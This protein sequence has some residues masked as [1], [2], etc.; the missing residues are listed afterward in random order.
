MRRPR[1]FVALAG[2]ATLTAATVGLQAQAPPETQKQTID[3]VVAL[4]EQ[5]HMSRPEINDDV[6]KRA[7]VNFI[8]SLDPL[9][10]NFLKADVDGFLAESP[11]LDDQIRKGDISWA[12]RVFQ[13]FLKRSDERLET[14]KAIFEQ[15]PDF[16]QDETI[17]DDP[18]LI[19]FPKTAEEA[20][21]RL[22]K[23]IKLDLLQLKVSKVDEADALK[24]L[25]LR[26]FEPN[27]YYKLF[28]N[29]DL[30][31]RYLTA[32][33]TAV[34]PHSAYWQATTLEDMLGTTLHL[35][36][37]GIGAS[38]QSEDGF[39]VVKEVVPGGAA[40]KDGRLQPEDKILGIEGDNGQKEEF[41]GKKLSDVVRKIR[42][43]AGT[44][45]RLM[46]Q[47]AE[48][49]EIKV[50]ELTRQK[51]ELVEQKA[52][53][54]VL[55]AKGPD[56]KAYKVGVINLP[57]FY[58]DGVALRNNAPD[59]VSAT[60]D[61]KRLL[62]GFKGQGVN[63]VVVDL[64]GNGGGLLKEAVML[65]GLFIDEGPVVQIKES[66][67]V[68]HHDDD[69]KGTA[70]DGPMVVLIDHFSA[71]ASEIF[72]GVI[73]D[74][75][76]GL[77]IGDSSTYG[78]GTVQSIIRLN[79]ILPRLFTRNSPD[80]GA[81][82]LTIQQ[83]YRANGESTQI[84]GVRPDIHIPSPTDYLDIGEGKSETAVKYDKVAPLA[85]DDYRRVPADLVTKIKARSEER[86]QANAKF[87]DQAKAIERL[88]ARK[89]KHEITLNEEKF[90]VE[91]AALED[92]KDD[93]KPKEKKKHSERPAWESNFYND[94]ILA[95]L[96]DYLSLG[97]D[98]LTAGPARDVDPS[99]LPLRP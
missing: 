91:T 71:S 6:A 63:A 96:G 72:A 37:E 38:L 2:I 4:L 97:G 32:L 34:D 92:D 78:K 67:G 95:I 43:P 16:T 52:K 54:Q 46:V 7:A 31:E 53:G 57:S 93:D 50:Y 22:R 35:S 5:E 3:S 60:A 19:D 94:E 86:R 23:Q 69:V 42:G 41:I 64:R 39:P 62:D 30:L 76:R 84:R 58:G 36:L 25:K 55:E 14:A 89:A 8:E 28:D 26:Y 85:H 1:G 90:R 20:A 18:K 11:Q 87:Q 81:L 10:Y 33:T 56:G 49:K 48:S 12:R 44:K 27:R 75:G 79:E 70:W 83:F 68:K 80:L 61:C 17:V 99:R 59:A 21:D 98:V 82:K 73:Q 51:I 88:R 29:E 15:K 24:R 66:T 65:S 40:D 9:K 74:Y 77:V 45:V 13:A 47:P